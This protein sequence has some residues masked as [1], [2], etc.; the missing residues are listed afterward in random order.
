MSTLAHD[1]NISI[2]AYRL[3]HGRRPVMVGLGRR[4]LEALRQTHPESVAHHDF[5]GIRIE[6]RAEESAM[7]FYSSG[8]S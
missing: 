5:S 2:E 7:H 8:W 4:E 3:T 1:L 6:E